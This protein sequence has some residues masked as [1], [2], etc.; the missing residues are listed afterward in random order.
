[1]NKDGK[2]ADLSSLQARHAWQGRFFGR[3][4]RWRQQLIR[5]WWWWLICPL[6]GLALQTG[7]W[8]FAKPRYVSCGRL[9]VNFKLSIAEGS[10]Y[11]EELNNFLGTQ[12]ALMQS[13]VVV[14]RA[15]ERVGERLP[16]SD[17]SPVALR[18]SIQPKTTIFVLEGKG[19]DGRYTRELVQACMEEYIN[20][21]KEMRAQ[22]SDTTLAGLTEE[23]FRLEKELRKCDGELV[24]FQSTNSVVLL[25]E[26]GNSAVNF[27]AGL[28]QR[29]AVAKSEYA[30]LVSLNPDQ[31]LERPAQFEFEP[32][33]LSAPGGTVQIETAVA[34]SEYLRA[35]QQLLLLRAE[36]ADLGQYLRPKHPRIVALM[37]QVARYQRLLTIFHEQ[38]A[39]Q[40][41][42]RKE[43]L[44]LQIRNLEEDVREWDQRALDV[45]RKSAE[46]QRLKANSQR[47]QGLY[48]R[49]LATMQTLDVNKQIS[50]ESVTILEKASPAIA[51][52]PALI[53]KLVVGALAG[54]VGSIFLL[55]LV[56]RLDD[57]IRWLSE[58]RELFSEEV[59]AQIPRERSAMRSGELALLQAEEDRYAFVESYRN[60]RSSLLFMGEPVQ[61]PRTILITSSVPNE[62]KSVTSANLAITLA[63]AGARALLVDAD[64]RKGTLHSR[65]GICSGVPGLSDVLE[66]Q[67]E[68]VP[69]IGAFGIWGNNHFAKIGSNNTQRP[70]CSN[71]STTPL[72]RWTEFAQ[73]TKVSSLFLLPRGN[74]THRSS[75]LFLSPGTMR[76]LDE[77]AIHYDF[78]ILD[79]PPV[80]AADDVTS[81]APHVDGVIFVM[82][83]EHTSMRIAR[84]A[85]D[86]LYL[87]NVKVLGLVVNAVPPANGDYYC[88]K[89]Y[90]TKQTV[91]V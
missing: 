70:D 39:Q 20:L 26:Q 11:T 74:V 29:L 84:A 56:D 81:L 33:I 7:T 31:N 44:L 69:T 5:R 6:L 37:D 19:E 1:M 46:F 61:R 49:L 54:A 24:A 55:M 36:M 63:S 77:A 50:P 40:L 9:I 83:A 25:Q 89:D 67:S 28:K 43:S 58:V 65:F 91:R 86:L 30:L 88:Y 16:E 38:T 35:R 79:T 12:A 47:A 15:H 57:R 82:R 51:E 18:A 17:L 80:M 71:G 42:N 32:S 22:T 8:W 87:R 52:H 90:L 85:L 27:L 76:F 62:G 14:S 34:G 75:E 72:P 48:D 45:S 23:V 73:S 78:V 13:G 59:L 60:L 53:H 21:K 64:L 66:T 2:P 3:F 68:P 10:I 4:N 41:E